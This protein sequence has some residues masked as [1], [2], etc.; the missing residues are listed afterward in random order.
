[1][2]WLFSRAWL[3]ED[4]LEAAARRVRSGEQPDVPRHLIVHARTSMGAISTDQSQHP[5]T[6]WQLLGIA[7]ANLLLTPLTGMAVWYGL[8]E[9]RPMA[10][11]QSLRVTLPIALGLAV[12]W[13]SLL[14]G[15]LIQ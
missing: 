15:Q 4:E 9:D 8:R 12:F 7:T 14:L 10:A 6:L 13:M 3:D 2:A 11:R 1:M 5:L